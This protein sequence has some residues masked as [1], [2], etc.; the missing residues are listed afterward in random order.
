MTRSTIH[1]KIEDLLLA[2]GWSVQAHT[3]AD[4]KKSL[5]IAIRD[6]PLA[7]GYGKIDYLLYLEGKA[8][9]LIEIDTKEKT[10]PGIPLDLPKYSRG[11]PFTL[12]RYIH[13]LPFLYQSRGT[14]SCF[15]NAFDPVPKVRQLSGFHRPETLRT[16]L[17]DGMIGETPRDMAAEHFPEYRRRG[18]S[19][20]ERMMINLP[21]LERDGLS[22]EQHKA[23]S[24]LEI[25]LGKNHPR[26]FVE[27]GTDADRRRVLMHLIERLIKFAGARRVLVLVHSA[28]IGHRLAQAIKSHIAPKGESSF[29]QAFPLQHLTE[30]LDPE[31]RLCITTLPRLYSLLS[32]RQPPEKEKDAI[33][34][35]S[36]SP[37]QYNPAFPIESFEVIILESPDASLRPCFH[38]VL[39]YF[40]A[41][42][43]ALMEKA[44]DAAADFF[45]QNSVMHDE[46]VESRP[47]DGLNVIASNTS[48]NSSEKIK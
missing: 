30:T 14:K 43:I 19:F 21:E 38:A 45:N 4:L 3:G 32:T 25:S 44:N 20:Q 8:A 48:I 46:T 39:N 35:L 13:P 10:L 12:R 16:W 6:F 31:A 17:E 40:D 42:L 29:T 22:T 37:L 5:G 26:A 33:D 24:N 23:I 1:A 15:T 7:R 2:A 47:S 18:R 28:D 27:M 41:Y 34:A 36:A 11:L 9:G